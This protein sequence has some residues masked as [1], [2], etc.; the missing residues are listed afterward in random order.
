M[1]FE[2]REAQTG[3]DAVILGYPGGGDF[4]ATPAR[5][6]AAVELVGRD[7]RRPHAAYT[8]RGTVRIGE[9]GGP[10]IDP[11]GKVLGVV[12]GAKA[13]DVDTGFV[14]TAGEVVGQMAKVVNTQQVATGACSADAAA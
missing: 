8:I 9:G 6:R 12:S 7:S 2:T 11:H 3:A 14:L 10:L 5:I 4:T 13:S 1:Q